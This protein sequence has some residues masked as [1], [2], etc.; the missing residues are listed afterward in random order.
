MPPKTA[1]PPYG[2]ASGTGSS[3]SIWQRNR[4]RRWKSIWRRWQNISTAM[5]S[6]VMSPLFPIASMRM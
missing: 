1:S 2:A 3:S 6:A 4:R 5:I